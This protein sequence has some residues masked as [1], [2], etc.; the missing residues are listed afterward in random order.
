MIIV[1]FNLILIILGAIGIGAVIYL[2]V[3][4]ERYYKYIYK[5][6]KKEKYRRKR[7]KSNDI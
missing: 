4:Q 2:D 3:M 5:E 6:L 7:K 1:V